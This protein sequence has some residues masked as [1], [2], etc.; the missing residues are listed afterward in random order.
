MADSNRRSIY[1]GK[2]VR[3]GLETV[4]LPHGVTIDLE[5][6]RHP[7]AAAVVPVHEDGSVTLI[8]QHRHA[9]GGM[10]Y[11]VPAGKLEPL[12]DPILC[13]GR[14]LEEEV[15]LRAGTLTHLSTIY[16]TP[17]FTDEQIHLY[18]ATDLTPASE[19]QPEADEFIEVV[20]LP[21]AEVLQ[22]IR[23]GRIV[24]GKSICALFLAL[25]GS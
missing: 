6:I 5:V 25:T 18:K 14:E 24:D 2:V 19:A 22:M 8:Y 1:E 21:P 11:E 23:D 10:I 4:T 3:L 12:E 17:G 15:Q 16:T 20:R 9:A 7:G 13:A